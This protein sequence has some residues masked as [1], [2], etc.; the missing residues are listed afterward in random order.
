MSRYTVKM[1]LRR[2]GLYA[3]ARQIYQR[4]SPALRK[5]RFLGRRFFQELVQTGDLCLDIGANVGQTIE[6]LL[7]SG[8]TVIAVEP[9]PHCIP[10]LQW[11][12]RGAKTLTIL[13]KAIGDHCGTALLY[14]R[15]TEPLASLRAESLSTG[16]NLHSANF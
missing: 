5:K 9:N 2:I 3:L 8:A 14:F 12:F 15:G 6:A 7:E 1:L 16:S 4:V 13:N 10:I 11:Q